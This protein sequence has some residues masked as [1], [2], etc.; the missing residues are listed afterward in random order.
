MTVR[1]RFAP[2]PTG[3]LHVGGA[4]TAL[5]NWLFARHNG[6]TFILRIEDTDRERST[7]ESVQAILDG[8]TWLGLDWDEGPGVGGPYGPYFQ[9]QRLESYHAYANRLLA[10]GRAYK[11]YCIP[12]ELEERRKQA[13]AE[14]RAP[15]YDRTCLGLSGEERQRREAE[16]RRPVIRFR[17]LDEG[18]TVLDDLIR[19]RI[20]FDNS[21]LDDFVL[22]KSD[23]MPT[24]NFAAVIDDAAM[25]ITHIIRGD[26]H[27]S[28]TPR[29][30]QVYQA[31]GL[32]LPQF[33][34]VPMILG[35]DKTRLS[36]RHGATAI[37][38]YREAGY[39]PETMVN[40]LALL[41]WSLNATET[42]FSREE[43]IKHFTLER[44]S[45]NPAVFDPKKLEW[46]NGVYLRKATPERLEKL[47]KPE[48]VAEGLLSEEEAADP[49]RREYLRKVIELQKTRLRTLAEFI[50]TSAYFFRDPGT[51]EEA[52]EEYLKKPYAAAA[53]RRLADR[54]EKLEAFAQPHLEEVFTGLMTELGLS[55][56]E[57]IHPARTA[58]TGRKVSPGIYDVVELLGREAV[59]RRLRAGAERAEALGE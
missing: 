26:D 55:A 44:C 12:E 56:G 24:Y 37:G 9:T 42:V 10:A 57:L 43:L 47:L 11:C 51:Y 20:T 25:E 4:R 21:T 36:K 2:S 13:L 45:K 6:G 28:N 3:Y 7:E 49:V 23:G 31:L 50:P 18:E 38:Q 40:Y 34:H 29:Q 54:L 48:L 15:K 46:L 32:P 16:G 1:V 52:A 58:L 19:G 35:S 33:A 39:L 53:L 27:I 5:F 41:G 17:T 59:V 14:G 8:L 30:I 22:L